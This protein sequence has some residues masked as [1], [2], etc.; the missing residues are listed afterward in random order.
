MRRAVNKSRRLYTRLCCSH[1]GCGTRP[2][3]H[4]NRLPPQLPRRELVYQGLVVGPQRLRIRHFLALGVQVEAV[5]VLYH[6]LQFRIARPFKLAV[7]SLSVPWVARVVPNN[8]KRLFGQLG[9]IV[10]QHLQYRTMATVATTRGELNAV[11]SG[12]AL[13]RTWYMYSS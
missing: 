7:I 2:W 8:C 1:C 10:P 12:V 5:E 9:I 13:H 3:D 4:W 6:F 11:V